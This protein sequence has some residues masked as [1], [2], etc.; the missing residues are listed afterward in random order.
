MRARDYQSWKINQFSPTAQS[1]KQ[2]RPPEGEI[3]CLRSHK[4][5]GRKVSLSHC[6]AVKSWAMHL[7]DILSGMTHV[8]QSKSSCLG[9]G[10]RA[11]ALAELLHTEAEG[12]R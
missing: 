5:V 9:K 8:Q 4:K 7:E 10:T 11:K 2:L 3:A 1:E 6:H 12:N